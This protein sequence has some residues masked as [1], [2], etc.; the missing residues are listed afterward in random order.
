MKRLS[1]SLHLYHASSFHCNNRNIIFQLYMK[2]TIAFNQMRN[3]IF[4]LCCWQI[5]Y[6]INLEMHF[7]FCYLRG[8]LRW[9]VSMT[10]G[11]RINRLE[12]H[13]QFHDVHDPLIKQTR[14]QCG[15]LRWHDNS[16]FVMIRKPIVDC[17]YIHKFDILSFSDNRRCMHS[18]LTLV[19]NQC[20]SVLITLN[21]AKIKIDGLLFCYEFLATM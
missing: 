12:K 11:Y 4:I 19:T 14:N 21:A 18:S 8:R 5:E 2:K 1:P 20:T 15:Y 17:Q 16:L 13:H 6:D 3:M 9:S 10:T 7:L